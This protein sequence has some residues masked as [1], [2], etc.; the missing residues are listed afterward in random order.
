MRFRFLFAFFSAFCRAGRVPGDKG[1]RD[2]RPK[3]A[4][5]LMATSVPCAR[6]PKVS[7]V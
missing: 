3:L 7:R 1:P 2:D 5:S 6:I 4:N